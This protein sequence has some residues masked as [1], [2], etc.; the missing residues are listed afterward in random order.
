MTPPEYSPSEPSSKTTDDLIAA[1]AHAFAAENKVTTEPPK[2]PPTQIQAEPRKSRPVAFY[3]AAAILLALGLALTIA[4][5][6]KP[7]NTA[8]TPS[9]S[10]G[11]LAV[12]TPDSSDTKGLSNQAQQDI[13]TCSN[14]VNAV[15]G[16]C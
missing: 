15:L 5:S 14:T 12:P 4:L 11:L 1:D 13:K 10:N 16:S 3:I 2:N 8:G 6:P 9:S 7:E